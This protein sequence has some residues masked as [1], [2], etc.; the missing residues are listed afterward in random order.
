MICRQCSADYSPLLPGCP[1]CYERDTKKQ[2]RPD[3]TRRL[4]DLSASD[5]RH[6]VQLD[7][8]PNCRFVTFPTDTTCPSC[9]IPLRQGGKILTMENV[10]PASDRSEMWRK[11]VFAAAIGGVSLVVL[12]MLFV[13]VRLMRL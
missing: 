4:P 8:C 12:L 2:V 11:A 5:T 3:T 13:L 1:H 9:G 7:S 6:L 10:Q